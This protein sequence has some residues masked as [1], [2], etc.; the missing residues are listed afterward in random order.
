[1]TDD[2]AGV[3][4]SGRQAVVSFPE[5]V[6]GPDA[7]R[8]GE[9][10]LQV[11][12]Q[13]AVVLIVDMS[14][15]IRCDQAA[16]D[17]VERAYL[18]TAAGR[19]ELRL[20]ISAPEVRSLIGAEGLDRLVPVYASLDAALAEAAP[21][22]PAAEALSQHLAVASWGATRPG[23]SPGAGS[24]VDEAVLRQLVDALDDG[25]ALASGDGTI[26]LANRRL[27]A[28]FGYQPSD[29][30]GQP[31]EMLI[32]P[33]LR[34]AHRGHRAAY[35]RKLTARPMADRARLA[36][37]RR[38]GST[39]PVTITLAP[40]PADGGH[41]VLAVVRDATHAQ[42]RDDLA[43]L[44]SGVTAGEAERTRELLDRVVAG[45]FQAGLSLRAAASLPVDVARERISDA[46][47]SLDD[48]I[49]EIRDHIFRSRPPGTAP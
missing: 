38:D 8:I 12:S 11:L 23:T 34:E 10:L 48:T 22:G 4:W 16:A 45:L 25:I 42:Q 1:M 15:T 49:H 2:G 46:L 33:G 21:D 24:P 20:V 5:E 43:V 35:E 6:S 39:V 31:V 36:G 28:M 26:V 17:A 47:Q 29:L 41:L 3:T 19:V 37:V 27:T 18:H 30:A 13:G 40:V 32:P 9:Q 44:L 7:V 14:A